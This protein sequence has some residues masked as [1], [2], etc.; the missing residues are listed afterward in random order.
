MNNDLE[1]RRERY[2]R[3]SARLAQL[4]TPTLKSLL[5]KREGTSVWGGNQQLV[6]DGTRLF[7]KQL[8]LT[9]LEYEN[10]FS[11]SNLYRLPNYYSYGVGSVGFRPFRELVSH[12]KT[13]N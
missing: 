9:D 7:V 4:D 5:G 13:T 8:L 10:A 6:L 12:I 1:K 3:L 11:T 2:N